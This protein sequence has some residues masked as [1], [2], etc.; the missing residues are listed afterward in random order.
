MSAANVIGIG[1]L[2]FYFILVGSLLWM[3]FPYIAALPI[4]PKIISILAILWFLVL[5]FYLLVNTDFDSLD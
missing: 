1:F 3:G 5:S 2:F 4:F